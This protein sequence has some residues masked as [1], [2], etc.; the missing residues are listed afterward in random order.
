MVWL[1]CRDLNLDDVE[2]EDF[3]INNAKVAL[4]FG[5]GFGVDGKGFA[6]I[7]IGCSKELLSEALDRIKLSV[8]SLCK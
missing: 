5:S 8:N 3:F 7:N 1:D 4:T 6:R 2:L